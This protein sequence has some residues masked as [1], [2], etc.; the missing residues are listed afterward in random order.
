MANFYFIDR[1]INVAD[2]IKTYTQ[3]LSLEEFKKAR[4]IIDAVI[5]NLELIGEAAKNIST[6]V[7]ED[8]PH[9]PWEKII[10]F[11]ILS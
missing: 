1:I 11:R 7:R 5:W 9:I 2:T 4:L 3:G 8:N 6:E 10:E